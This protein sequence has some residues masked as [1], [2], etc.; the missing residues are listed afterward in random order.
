M[1]EDNVRGSTK[2]IVNG[3]GVGFFFSIFLSL[4]ISNFT[5]IALPVWLI[6]GILAPLIS[7]MSIAALVYSSKEKRDRYMVK[8]W[9]ETKK[10]QEEQDRYY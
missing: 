1:S 8:Y 6:Y 3:I 2:D 4:Y 7:A 5:G 10:K 9:E